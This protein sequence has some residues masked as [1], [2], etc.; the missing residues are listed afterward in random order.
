MNV[1][2]AYF[3]E[4]L[5]KIIY[6]KFPEEYE[7]AISQQINQSDKRKRD[8]VLRLLRPLYDLKQSG[9]VLRKGIHY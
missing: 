4:K 5:K 7:P 3:K 8:R 9:Q 6:M 1:S 2:N